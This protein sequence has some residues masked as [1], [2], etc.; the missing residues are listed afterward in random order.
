[1]R[2][3]DFISPRK[4]ATSYEV[5][6][7]LGALV[8]EH[9]CPFSAD[10]D[11]SISSDI[12][13]NGQSDVIVHRSE[14][15]EAIRMSDL[16]INGSIA[17]CLKK[18]WKKPEVSET[19]NSRNN[20]EKKMGCD[21][22]SIYNN[23][24]T[25]RKREEDNV[26]K[27]TD[28]INKDEEDEE[29]GSKCECKCDT[30]KDIEKKAKEED[31]FA[32]YKLI[33][34]LSSAKC[35][36]CA[37]LKKINSEKRKVSISC[38]VAAYKDIVNGK[39]NMNKDFIKDR[40]NALS[41][42]HHDET[43]YG[44]DL[45]K[46]VALKKYQ[47]M[48]IESIV[49]DFGSGGS[50]GG[51]AILPCGSGKGLIMLRAFLALAIPF[52]V[53][54]SSKTLILN[55]LGELIDKF[56]ILEN[57]LIKKIGVIGV[58]GTKLFKETTRDDDIRKAQKK[59]MNRKLK[60][61]QNI[62]SF[63][64]DGKGKPPSLL[65]VNSDMFNQHYHKTDMYQLDNVMGMYPII[66]VDEAHQLRSDTRG[67]DVNTNGHMYKCISY[68]KTKDAF[69]Y[70][71]TQSN[72]NL[73]KIGLTFTNTYHNIVHEET[74]Y[75]V[76]NVSIR[77]EFLNVPNKISH[78]DEILRIYKEK[79]KESNKEPPHDYMEK[80]SWIL[81]PDRLRL[82]L[83]ILYN[84]MKKSRTS[85]VFFDK[86]EALDV[87]KRVLSKF[88]PPEM[89]KGRLLSITGDNPS[90]RETIQRQIEDDEGGYILL[91]TGAVSTGW[92]VP[93]I[94]V[95][96]LPHFDTYVS[97]TT[98]QKLG[99]ALRS[100]ET[101]K[102]VK[103]EGATVIIMYTDKIIDDDNAIKRIQ[104]Y[105]DNGLPMCINPGSNAST[106][107]KFLNDAYPHIINA[108]DSGRPI[109]KRVVERVDETIEPIVKKLKELMKNGVMDDNGEKACKLAR[110]LKHGEDEY[111][112]YDSLDNDSLN[113]VIKSVMDKAEANGIDKVE[114]ASLVAGYYHKEK[115][116]GSTQR[117]IAWEAAREAI[118]CGANC[119]KA[120]IF[121]G[122]AA[123]IYNTDEQE[124]ML[125]IQ[126]V[127]NCI[128]KQSNKTE[129]T[130]RNLELV[131][132]FNH[133]I[134]EG[135]NGKDETWKVTTIPGI[136]KWK[137]TF[138]KMG[139]SE[140]ERLDDTAIMNVLNLE[141]IVDD[142]LS[143]TSA[144]KKSAHD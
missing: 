46:N 48:A 123:Y 104:T 89:V 143:N 61:G 134:I 51:Y 125:E 97:Q 1:M 132:W 74:F 110:C 13:L 31:K 23:C 73:P 72:S 93:K 9:G 40:G 58:T 99:R 129:D 19:L 41:V 102:G 81:N 10:G 11:F 98:V 136:I 79:C 105:Y 16:D 137:E 113:K 126:P 42:K 109:D 111:R 116:N 69:V 4:Y 80:V 35:E 92:N 50:K 107:M 57:G 38:V 68:L 127:Y 64:V 44:V 18:G 30:C 75:R 28:E 96:L 121:G 117:T 100:W 21:I 33:V 47:K 133:V 85:I 119:D 70:G 52:A 3:H 37:I 78:V 135:E 6:R 82:S 86:K 67:G 62:I 94:S 63:N 56:E 76:S 71:F 139:I 101:K 15:P 120:A 34:D 138:T 45:L 59:E 112:D 53:V 83:I 49:G 27:Y 131:D 29:V 142:R 144:R 103:K 141:Q 25:K 87:F 5:C 22:M 122:E 32:S 77:I 39:I 20:R 128:P 91:A 90:E 106:E 12:L 54:A 14:H 108:Y 36:K 26:N 60:G 43:L 115:H 124:S 24:G 130:M 118:K 65:F 66:V 95:V 8:Q 7:A 84:A 2:R 55:I 114:A 17:A 88:L 140:W